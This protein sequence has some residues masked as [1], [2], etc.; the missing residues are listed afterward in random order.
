MSFN[1]HTHECRNLSSLARR[2]DKIVIFFL[3]EKK[4]KSH[5]ELYRICRANGGADEIE[6]K[7]TRPDPTQPPGRAAPTE[8]LRMM[9]QQTAR[10]SQTGVAAEE[11]QMYKTKPAR[12]HAHRKKQQQ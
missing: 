5:K 8:T 4:K 11:P 12:T 10:R 3:L 9:L 1:C 2:W 6:V 7:N